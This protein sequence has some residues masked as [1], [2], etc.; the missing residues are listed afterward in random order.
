MCVYVCVCVCV[1][2][3]MYI[4]SK[5]QLKTLECQKVIFIQ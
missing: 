1:N 2:A 4:L 3:S 5:G